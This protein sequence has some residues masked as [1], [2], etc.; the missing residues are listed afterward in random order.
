MIRPNGVREELGSARNGP[1]RRRE[2]VGEVFWRT[3]T[4]MW[5]AAGERETGLGSERRVARCPGATLDRIA[6]A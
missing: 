4:E 1:G 6:E 5:H 2:R 3:T